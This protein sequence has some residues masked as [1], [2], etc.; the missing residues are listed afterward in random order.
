[1]RI[2]L[3]LRKWG[4][5]WGL[6]DVQLKYLWRALDESRWTRPHAWKLLM[7]QHELAGDALAVIVQQPQGSPKTI[8]EVI[9]DLVGEKRLTRN[10]AVVIEQTILS[11][12]GPHGQWTGEIP[13]PIRHREKERRHGSLSRG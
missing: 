9:E 2:P 5:F 7:H 10:S 13:T 4:V 6:S 11:G 3:L 8:I 12:V 1:M